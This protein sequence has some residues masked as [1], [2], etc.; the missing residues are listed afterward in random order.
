MHV[1][2]QGVG[3]HRPG[4][5][6]TVPHCTVCI[7]CYDDQN[8]SVCWPCAVWP[9]SSCCR[10]RAAHSDGLPRLR[11]GV[12][13]RGRGRL[14]PPTRAGDELSSH[15]GGYDPGSG[16]SE[17][18]PHEGHRTNAWLVGM[19]PSRYVA[20]E[21]PLIEQE[22]TLDFFRPR[23]GPCQFLEFERKVILIIQGST[24]SL[25]VEV[26]VPWAAIFPVSDVDLIPPS[27]LLIGGLF[28]ADI[29][30]HCPRSLKRLL[31]QVV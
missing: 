11:R 10:E 5:R 2:R 4:S 27:V 25:L 3:V 17:L 15:R 30:S 24:R 7:A 12:D 23:E 9:S 22:A 1:R 28:R 20:L 26:G 31:N 14:V 6:R 8:T 21:L 18:L 13:E 16:F 29:A 19:L